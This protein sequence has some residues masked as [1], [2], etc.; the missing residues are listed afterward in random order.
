MGKVSIVPTNIRRGIIN[1]ALLKLTPSEQISNFFL[2]YW[3][4]SGDFQKGL[5]AYSMGAAIQNVASVKVLKGISVLL[6][7]IKEQ[8]NIVAK[9][10]AL[11]A[12]TKKLEAIYKQKLTNLDEL[13]KSVL[14]K[15][16]NGQLTMVNWCTQPHRQ[17]LDSIAVLIA[18]T[19]LSSDESSHS[20]A[21]GP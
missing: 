1:Q 8:L 5:K 20:A 21:L 14:K 4:E 11:S 7:P 3:M 15:A 9:L 2:K 13:K 12:E 6:P 19:S 18:R 10:D 16:F 17:P